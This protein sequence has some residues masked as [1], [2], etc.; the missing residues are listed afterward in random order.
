MKGLENHFDE[1]DRRVSFSPD[2]WEGKMRLFGAAFVCIAVL[3]GVDVL[4]FDGRY[5][6]GVDR[7]VWNIY[8][9]W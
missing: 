1:A 7:V 4:F 8:R 6:D 5:G 3:Y 2:D 9:H